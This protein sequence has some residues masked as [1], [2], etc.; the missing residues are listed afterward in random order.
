[1]ADAVLTLAQTYALVFTTPHG[2][3]VLDDLRVRFGDRQSFVPESPHATSYHEGQRAVYLLI[4]RQLE[5][6]HDPAAHTL[7]VVGAP[8]MEAA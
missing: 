7:T 4:C 3:E 2:R 8:E 6:A 1:M 5:Y